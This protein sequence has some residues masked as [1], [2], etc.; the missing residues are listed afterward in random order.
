MECLWKHCSLISSWDISPIKKQRR[1]L[2]NLNH[3]TKWAN[4]WYG[5]T[6]KKKK[7]G[8]QDPEMTSLKYYSR[9]VLTDAMA[10]YWWVSI[11]LWSFVY[12]CR[13]ICWPLQW[14][15]PMMRHSAAK[16]GLWSHFIFARTTHLGQWLFFGGFFNC[17]QNAFKKRP[18]DL[19]KIAL[20]V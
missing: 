9:M 3:F 1:T 5:S 15:G 14:L 16:H 4:F 7:V 13:I 18:L 20:W 2:Y 19:Y 10:K 8:I 12:D 17:Y 11:L 6:L